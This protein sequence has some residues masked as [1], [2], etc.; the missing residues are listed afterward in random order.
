MPSS[1]KDFAV[2][3]K[4]FIINRRFLVAASSMLAFIGLAAAFMQRSGAGV[5]VV[6][7]RPKTLPTLLSVV[8]P[9]TNHYANA[10]NNSLYVLM[11]EA[12]F[13]D[14]KESEL[15]DYELPKL[16]LDK[17]QI[18][19]DESVSLTWSMGRD[20]KNGNVMLSE[21]DII[22]LY[23]GDSSER[24]FLEAAT[25]AQIR[26][27][28]VKNKGH[29]DAWF[30]PA[31]P[32]LRQDVCHFRLYKLDSTAESVT[33][34]HISSSDDLHISLAK[35][36]PTAIHLALS[37]NYSKMVVS[38]TTGYLHK[39]VPVARYSIADE[40]FILI[41][42][43]SDTYTAKNLCQAPANL[44][45]AGKFYDPGM[46]HIVE[47]ENLEPDT[48]YSYQV[49]LLQGEIV[50]AWSDVYSFTSAPRE[51][52]P[53]EF[54][55]IVY[56]DQGCPSS[57]W[58][59][60]R[61]WL[62]TMMEREN[63]TSIHHFGDISYA[64]GAAHIWDGWFQMIQPF[65]QKIPLM[66]GI[67]NHE[68]DHMDGGAHGKD[69]SGV[70]TPHGFM[71]VWGDFANDSGG[72]C[73]VPM[74]KRFNMPSSERS[75]GVFWYSYEYASVHTTV[76][77]SEHDLSRGSPQHEF[78]KADLKNVDRK[79]TPWL[80]VESHRPLY[81]GEGGDHWWPNKL[82]GENM[83]VEI[84]GLLREFKVDLVLAGHY[85]EY[86]RTC[87]GLYKERCDLGGP[88]HITVGSAGGFLDDGV[89]FENDWTSRYIRGEY[90]YGRITVANA[91]DMHFEFVRHGG[92]DDPN[93]GEIL[94][95]IWIH[96]DRS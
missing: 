18:H 56:G 49:G 41:H 46:L 38:F 79:V 48:R 93:S 63:P 57:G 30:I 50:F 16:M 35:E 54:S 59:D 85:H 84:E 19:I 26:I 31:F 40:D 23:C 81:E 69:P 88:I 29:N 51:G 96:R 68:Y 8:D 73:G 52:D 11:Q 5:V 21:N 82:V 74:S 9:E 6:V 43:R 58:T 78:L 65:S 80:V 4:N 32:I 33:L 42:G 13:I 61:N 95:E 90:G 86:H 67:G 62:L 24:E 94:D 72:E 2:K 44:T 66:I 45:E 37:T 91:T 20:W 27:T 3:A 89:E 76:I 39:V 77:S 7:H 87:D 83:R 53:K 64:N 22:A 12:I 55:Y 60:G 14:A 92:Q 28:S 34:I 17:T 15:H 1:D 75:N 70:E 71:P 47:L 25:I 10:L 36:T